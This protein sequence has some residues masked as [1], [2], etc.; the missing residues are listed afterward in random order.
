MTRQI[1]NAVDAGEGD[2]ELR[3][4]RQRLAVNAK[5][6]DARMSLAR[7]Y[8]QRGLPDLALEH[9]RMA[10]VQFPDSPVV[11]FALTKT[12][13]EMGQPTEALKAAGDFLTRHP[14]GN[15]ELLSLAGILEDEQGQFA[16]AE[17][18]H[19]AALALEPT[20]SALL[21]NLGYNLLLQGKLNAATAQFRRAM[22]ADPRSTVARNNMETALAAQAHVPATALS[23]WERSADPATAHTNLAAVLIEQGKYADARF[24]LETALRYHR[25]FPPAVANLK[26]VAERDAQL[27]ALPASDPVNFWK[28]VASSVGKYI[29]GPP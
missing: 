10:A 9:D 17:A 14:T 20:R 24:E 26:L 29:A 21:N 23:E 2:L 27:A 22:E 18:S 25:D 11:A 16:Q 5:D 3:R 4:L 28:R 7:L 19:R 12:L 13:R 15:W 1:Q 8:L 6:L